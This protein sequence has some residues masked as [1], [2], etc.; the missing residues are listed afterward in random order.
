MD[1]S[2]G[3]CICN[4][5]LKTKNGDGFAVIQW[6]NGVDFLAAVLGELHDNHGIR[7][8]AIDGRIRAADPRKRLTAERRANLKSA[9]H[10]VWPDG[11]YD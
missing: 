5:C 10:D 3:A 2:S 11:R 1:E 7:V 9:I 8:A 4:Q 6:A